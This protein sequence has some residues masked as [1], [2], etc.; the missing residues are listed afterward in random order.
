MQHRQLLGLGHRGEQFVGTLLGGLGRIGPRLV[1]GP[2]HRA[3][4]GGEGTGHQEGG[5][6]PGEGGSRFRTAHDGS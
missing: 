4:E 2:R 6:G 5:E 3:A 1:G